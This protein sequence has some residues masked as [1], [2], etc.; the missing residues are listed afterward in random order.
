MIVREREESFI[1]I[2]QNCHGLLAE[3]IMDNW[4]EELF[5]ETDL[6]QSVLTAIRLHDVG[7]APFDRQPFWNDGKQAPYRFTD[8]PLLSK[9]VLY[10]HGIDT[11]EAVDPYAAMLCSEHYSHFVNRK[12]GEES[13]E[14]L[15]REE[16]RRRRLSES[17]A[18]FNLKLFH[19]HYALL[20]FGD[21]FSLYA[22]VNEPGVSKENEHPFFVNGIPSPETLDG[23]PHHRLAIR[24][25]DT[26]VIA[27][28]D[29][30]FESP[31]SV[32]YPYKEIPKQRISDIGFL[33]AY[34]ETGTK[35]TDLQFVPMK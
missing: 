19:E 10:R 16:S 20:Q 26:E 7:W 15:E 11:V 34:E 24:F 31:F 8:F 22:C 1:L 27:V 28:E 21:N 17:M 3:Q 35:R 18:D 32:S 12:D 25:T 6:R 9:L 33:K 5:P 14:F 2:E 29:F 30:P 13:A 4:K 23:L